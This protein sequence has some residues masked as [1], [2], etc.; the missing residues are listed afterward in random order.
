MKGSITRLKMTE[1]LE[2]L[3]LKETQT[4]SLQQEFR[5]RKV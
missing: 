4:P 3:L 1:N 2:V 5:N